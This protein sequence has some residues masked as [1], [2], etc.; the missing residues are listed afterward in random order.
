MAA[1]V[2]KK[3]KE[4]YAASS[5]KILDEACAVGTA[6]GIE[7][8]RVSVISESPYYAIIKQ[9]AKSKCD[10]IMMASH[11]RSGL[12]GFLLGSETQKVLTHCKIPVLV[13]R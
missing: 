4:E 5:K 7:C 11:G 1:P 9:A 13:V 12:E 2:E 10:L 6:A 8:A 3:Y